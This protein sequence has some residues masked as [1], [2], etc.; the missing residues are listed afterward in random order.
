MEEIGN[1]LLPEWH[2][3]QGC[4]SDQPS[5]EIYYC[6][7]AILDNTI[8]SLNLTKKQVSCTL[9]TAQGIQAYQTGDSW[10]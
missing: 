2:F 10:I 8:V 6:K 3:V 4:R 9:E 5:F 1:G 7:F